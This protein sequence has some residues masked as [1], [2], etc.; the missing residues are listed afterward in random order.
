MVFRLPVPPLLPLQAR[1]ENVARAGSS[2][3]SP[4]HTPQGSPSKHRFPPGAHELPDYL[5][6]ALDLGQRL[7]LTAPP[8]G[9]ISTTTTTTTATAT[10]RAVGPTPPSSYQHGADSPRRTDKENVS[11]AAAAAAAAGAAGAAGRP[12]FP[13]EP[14][15]LNHAAASRQEPYRATAVRD[16]KDGP[17]TAKFA[18]QP[19]GRGLSADELDKLQKPS[20][21]RLANVTQLCKKSR[22]QE[23]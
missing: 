11:P 14:S 4:A 12:A 9:A 13:K 6:E 16:R 7:E 22:N 23:S 21:R 18:A 2:F 8:K 3:T 20:V 1:T 17:G 15:F 10:I 19:V 5:D